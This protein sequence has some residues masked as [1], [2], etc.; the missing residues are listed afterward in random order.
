MLLLFSE[1]FRHLSSAT[2]LLHSKKAGIPDGN[3]ILIRFSKLWNCTTKTISIIRSSL[4]NSPLTG[5][6]ILI[7]IALPKF[8][9]RKFLK[10]R[11]PVNHTVMKQT[12][13]VLIINF[14][15]TLRIILTKDR[16][17]IK[18]VILKRVLLSVIRLPANME[19]PVRTLILLQLR[20]VMQEELLVE[21]YR[22]QP[23]LLL[24]Q[25]IPLLQHRQF[26][27]QPQHRQFQHQFQP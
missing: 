17:L 10:I 22:F 21:N 4:R 13:A 8:I 7:M 16:E 20:L 1:L 11:L 26:Q 18:P 2:S 24:F 6:V 3:P 9:W 25:Q 5:S 19:Y 14:M 15:P 12:R 27:H 23:H